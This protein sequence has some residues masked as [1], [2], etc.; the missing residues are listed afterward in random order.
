[1][2]LDLARRSRPIQQP[3]LAALNR[4][5]ESARYYYFS[6]RDVAETDGKV[7]WTKALIAA[8]AYR[9]ASVAERMAWLA[10]MAAAGL[11]TISIA[12]SDFC[13]A[14]PRPDWS[15]SATKPPRGRNDTPTRTPRETGGQLLLPRGRPPNPQ[16]SD[17]VPGKDT[18]N[19]RKSQC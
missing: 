9:D 13:A 4:L 5:G 14:S 6:L 15:V 16:N 10:E 7:A 18:Q 1:M 11:I 3:E 17:R 2:T 19:R 12:V 8:S